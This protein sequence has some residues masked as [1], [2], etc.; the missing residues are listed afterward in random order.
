M[1]ERLDSVKMVGLFYDYTHSA[2]CLLGEITLIY[3]ENGVGK[4]TLAAILDSLRERNSGEILR[5]RTLPGDVAPTVAVALDGKVYTFDGLG[6]DDRPPN[7]TLDVFYPGFVSRNVHAVTGVDPEQRRN[8][9]ELVLGRSA[10]A[11]VRRLTVADGEARDAL[12][13]KNKIEAD[14]QLLIKKPDTL[15]T[16]LGLLND[17]DIEARL[18]KTRSEQKQAQSRETILARAV[19]QTVSLEII[20]RSAVGEF[21]EKSA[22]RIGIGV[23]ALV[24]EHIAEHL[25]ADG[26]NWLARGSRYITSDNVCPFC[27]QDLGGSTLAKA[28]CSYFGAEYRAHGESLS[29]EIQGLRERLN[30]AAF[31]RIRAEVV[32]QVAVATQWTDTISV[33]QAAVDA[34]LIDAEAA[35]MRGTAK[36]EELIALK[37]SHPLEGVDAVLIDSAFADYRAATGGLLQVNRI[38]SAS[39][40]MAE[41][42]KTV[43]SR[44]DT[45]EIAERLCHLENQKVRFEPLAQ[46]LIA[47]RSALV[48]KRLKLDG[49]KTELKKAIDEHA[50]RVVGKYQNGINHYLD[51]FGCDVRIESVEPRFPSGKA[52]VQYKLRAHGHEIPLGFSEDEPCFETVLSEGDKNTLALSFFF[53]RL[54][55]C[56]T[57]AGRVVVLDD[58]VNSLGSSRRGLIEAVIRDLRTRG[59]QLIVLTHDERLAALMWR[60]KKLKDI[61]SLQVERTARNGSRLKPWDV[62]RA[63]QS[64]YVENYLTLV[65]Y[66]GNGG[67]HKKAAGCIRPYLE[68]RLRY[69][70][71]GPP[72]QTRDSLGQMIGRIR[73][74]VPGARLHVLQAKLSDLESINDAALPSHHATDDVPGMTPLSQ[75][76]VRLFA[77]KALDVLG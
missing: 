19:P 67:D 76:G 57:L 28:I 12:S 9:C 75:E 34:A 21:L 4:S 68:Q 62:E 38:L 70:Y 42:Q 46:D 71:P 63:T 41:G 69:L 43:L 13:E 56:E 51:F 31:S 48:E 1:L 3:G 36:L 15:G 35:W 11:N 18:D 22:D 24:K 61:V 64:E 32:I 30:L 23:E 37:K 39:R 20:D 33:D 45:A 52:S 8:L 55:D 25:G 54:K 7:E 14:I 77:Q 44:S 60:D 27:A 2:D 10:I 40:E 6:W 17:P 53:A 26:E 65:D 73:D 29:A 74:S 16:F 66:L 47:R 58:P 49:E 59:A 5:R 72:F 50:A